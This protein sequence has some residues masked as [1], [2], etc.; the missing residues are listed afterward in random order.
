MTRNFGQRLLWHMGEHVGDRKR[1]IFGEH[2]VWKCQ[3]EFAAVWRQTLDRMR[4]AGWEIPQIAGSDI[5][6]EVMA[7]VV[8]RGDARVAG[9][10]EGPLGFLVPMQFTHAAGI[11]PHIDAGDASS[12]RAILAA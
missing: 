6:G 1:A 7:V 11:E 3:Q 2:S 12:R 10:H 4:N 5:G 9:E 8:D